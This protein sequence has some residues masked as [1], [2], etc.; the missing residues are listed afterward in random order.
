MD[1][2]AIKSALLESDSF[3]V[4]TEK[5]VNLVGSDRPFDQ[6]VKR[7]T[8]HITTGDTLLSTLSHPPTPTWW[9]LVDKKIVQHKRNNRWYVLAGL[10][11]SGG[12]I[13]NGTS[14]FPV[15]GETVHMDCAFGKKDVASWLPEKGEFDETFCLPFDS[16][17]QLEPR[18]PRVATDLKTASGM[19]F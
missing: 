13:S 4:T 15:E 8:Y 6:M 7:S 18:K 5:M 16:I 1:D 19:P 11:K 17:E 3:T 2:T 12:F 9:V 10:D 14:F